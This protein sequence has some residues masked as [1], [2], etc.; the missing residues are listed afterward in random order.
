MTLDTKLKQ[1]QKKFIDKLKI[2]KIR[3][4]TGWCAEKME[5]YVDLSHTTINKIL[6]KH[7]LTNPKLKIPNNKGEA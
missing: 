2:I 5:S 4:K 6:V 3:N 1:E 7:G